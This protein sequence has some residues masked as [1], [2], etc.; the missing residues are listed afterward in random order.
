MKTRTLA[1][2]AACAGLLLAAGA[3]AADDPLK[4]GTCTNCHDMDK[5]KVGP[6]LK[7]A[8]AKNQ[9]K[10]AE[11]TAKIKDGKGHPKVNKPEADIKAAV[12]ATLAVK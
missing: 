11:L 8:S 9:G 3:N 4:A 6:S 7:D 2:I 5:K 10:S 12:D 1:L